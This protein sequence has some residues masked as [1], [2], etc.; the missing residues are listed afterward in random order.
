M[1]YPIKSGRLP[2]SRP[3]FRDVIYQNKNSS[4]GKTVFF[5]V[6]SIRTDRSSSVGIATGYGLDDPGIESRWGRDFSHTSRQVLGPTQPPV[7][8]VLGLSQMQSGRGVMLT[9][10]TLLVPR[11]RK[12][13]AIS[14]PTP[15]QTCNGT[16]FT[17]LITSDLIHI[18][19]RIYKIPPLDH[20]L[21]QLIP[22]N[23]PT[24][25]L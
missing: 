24:L 22:I 9:T 12:V 1:V 16:A 3:Q 10:H 17:A 2:K 18:N 5:T 20:N 14:L 13:R 25:L 7:Q 21:S 19:Y 11:S 6:A 15:V 4:Q 23:I 8:C